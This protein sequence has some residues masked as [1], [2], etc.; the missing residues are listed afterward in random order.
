MGAGKGE[1]GNTTGNMGRSHGGADHFSWTLKG[2]WDF[3]WT[4]ARIEEPEGFLA[5]EIA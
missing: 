4:G 3:W 2:G 1:A 5:E